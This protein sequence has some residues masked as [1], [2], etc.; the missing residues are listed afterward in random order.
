MIKMIIVSYIG[1]DIFERFII[2]YNDYL[3]L[4]TPIKIKYKSI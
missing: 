1:N 3:N 4:E 2:N